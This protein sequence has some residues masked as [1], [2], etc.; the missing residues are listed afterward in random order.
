MV[1]GMPTN[2]HPEHKVGRPRALHDDTIFRAVFRVL[3]RM[4]P[5]QL[6][7]AA[8]A[9]E[10]GC[11]P[12]ALLKRFGSKRKLLL[13]SAEWSVRAGRAERERIRRSH[14]S[15][16]MALRAWLLLPAAP[17]TDDLAGRPGFANFLKLYV[18]EA[19]DPQFHAVWERWIGE[20]EAG[21]LQ[22]LNE[23][24]MAGELVDH[25]DAV[26]LGR[27]LHLAMAGAGVLWIGDPRW[28]SQNRSRDAYEMIV[29]PWLR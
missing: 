23:A 19:T 11:S 6:T 5:R 1:D 22:M 27:A 17:G 9:A 15:P 14:A 2:D 20:Y 26:A 10:L 25:V 3:A 16:L 29:G 12:P 13:A 8:V 21:I 24:V 18:N 4:G 28:S 7:L